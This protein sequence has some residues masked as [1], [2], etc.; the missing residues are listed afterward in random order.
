MIIDSLHNCKTY[1][2]MHP[3]FAKAFEYLLNADFSKLPDGRNEIDGDELF[4]LMNREGLKKPEDA[5]LEVHDKYI[6]I[7]L[8]IDGTETF[9]WKERSELDSP[10][11]EFDKEKDIQF[12]NDAPATFYTLHSGQMSIF[13]PEDGHAPQIGEG[14]LTK[15][16]IKVLK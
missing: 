3:R 10:R 5:P 14:P 8:V 1:L 4:L 11:G 13:F 9:G 6:D 15:C 16:I 7:Q 2:G 12:F